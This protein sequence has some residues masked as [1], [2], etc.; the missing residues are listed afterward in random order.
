MTKKSQY[1]FEQAKGKIFLFFGP[2]PVMN[3]YS[4]KFIIKILL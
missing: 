2:N 1:V 4:D 3:S